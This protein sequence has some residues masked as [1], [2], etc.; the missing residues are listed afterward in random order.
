MR[1]SDWSS[2]V[3]S[4]DLLQHRA[5]LGKHREIASDGFVRSFEARGQLLDADP[6][7]AAHRLG[8]LRLPEPRPGL[9]RAQLH[10]RLTFPMCN[11]RIHRLS[12]N[13]LK[14]RALF[15][16][17]WSRSIDRKGKLRYEEQTSE[18]KYLMRISTDD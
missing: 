5:R 7:L 1:I 6:A 13:Y 9:A 14:T 10:D 15:K 18:L 12:H 11:D 4:S 16:F 8:D 2:D 17:I 3:C